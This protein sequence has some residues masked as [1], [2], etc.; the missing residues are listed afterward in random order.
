MP[1]QASTLD[2]YIV[3]DDEAVRGGFARLLR[4]AGLEVH[5]I[6]SL[7]ALL[8]TEFKSVGACIV[9]DMGLID[10][11]HREADVR[12]FAHARRIPI[13]AVSAADNARVRDA[14]RRL[15]AQFLLRKPV[16]DQ[17]LIDALNWVT[18][19]HV[20]AAR[21]PVQGLS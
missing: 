20:C 14:A 21:G 4:S 10:S 2:I 1:T 5:G 19:S 11:P 12:L 16:D 6:D 13:V 15:G 9:L 7:A 18:K 3:D 8:Q 17:A